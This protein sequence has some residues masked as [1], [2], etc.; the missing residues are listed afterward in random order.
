[1]SENLTLV[2]TESTE[3]YW[4]KLALNVIND[5]VKLKKDRE[6]EILAERFGI[7]KSKKTLNAIGIKYGVTRE[8]IRQI[9]NNALR[10]IRKFCSSTDAQKRIK[11]IENFVESK[12]GFSTQAALFEHFH[13]TEKAEQNAL[14]FIADISDKLEVFKDSNTTKAGWNL[15]RTKQ[16]KIKDAIKKAHATLKEEGKE[17]PVKDLVEKVGLEAVLL[18]SAMEA[19]KHIMRTDK[20]NWGLTSWPQVNPRSIRDKSKYIMIRHSKPIH[21]TEL[22][23]KIGEMGVKNVTKQSVHNELIKNNDFVLVGRGIYALSEWGYK[24]GVVEEVIVEVLTEAG[25]PLHKNDI[26]ERVLEKRIVK[27]STVILN[28]QKDKFKRVGKAVYTLN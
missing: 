21:Y 16:S 3:T 22:T 23:K 14:V 19:S 24:P 1:M 9:V 20:G 12:G 15:P 4:E 25:Q 6:K 17:T 28:L 2:G 10:K 26:I 5:C 18:E 7:G 8:R 27:A 11:E 13:T